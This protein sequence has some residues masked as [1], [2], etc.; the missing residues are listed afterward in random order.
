MLELYGLKIRTFGS[1]YEPDEDTFLL[2][3]ALEKYDFRGKTVLE[4]GTGSGIIALLLAK[5]AKKAAA[6]DINP[7]AVA[8]AKSNAALNGISNATFI[9]SDLFEN[10]RGK[11]DVIIFNPPYLPPEENPERTAIKAA[12][13]ADC[14]SKEDLCWNG[15]AEGR[16]AINRFIERA[17]QFL[18]RSGAIFM[19]ES[20]LSN[21]RKTISYFKK[22]GF[23]CK[24]AGK[25]KLD[26]EELVVLFIS[27]SV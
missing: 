14:I 5:T 9:E 12:N 27:A 26:W 7:E 22:C 1:V 17:P 11:F 13:C 16:Q 21:Y 10:V 4:M 15:G 25:K 19:L 8:C 2:I 18:K 24:I 23:S 6:V 20:S 3:S